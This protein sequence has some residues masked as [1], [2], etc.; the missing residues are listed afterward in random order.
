MFG[1]INNDSRYFDDFHN[2]TSK[3]GVLPQISQI[4][5]YYGQY[6]VGIQVFYHTLA[7]YV[8]GGLNLGSSTQQVQP[9]QA[10]LQLDNDEYITVFK[11][12]AGDIVD[13]LHNIYL[14][15]I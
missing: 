9:F 10:T 4:T 6:V 14:Y 11:G 13:H 3:L 8:Q 12:W 15:Y 2:I 7:G 1:N 5:V